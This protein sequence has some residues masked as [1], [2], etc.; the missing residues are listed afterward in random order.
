MKSLSL[1]ETAYETILEWIVSG[2]LPEGSVTSEIALTGVLDM[3]RTPVRAALQ[4]LETEGYVRIA[5]K[6]GVHIVPSSAWRVGDLLETWIAL[7]QFVYGLHHRSRKAEFAEAASFLLRTLEEDT[8]GTPDAINRLEGDIWRQW[9]ALGQNREMI[10]LHDMT[11]AKLRW[12][13]NDRRWR[14]PHRTET[15]PCL[16]NLL[17]AVISSPEDSGPDFFAYLH[18]LKKTWH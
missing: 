9:V 7:I 16:R 4:Q 17:R 6:H 2:R 14:A 8:P 15:E 3:S 5:P 18:I 11:A 12:H 13:R 1:R 10:R